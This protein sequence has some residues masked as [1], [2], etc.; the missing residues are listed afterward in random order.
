MCKKKSRDDFF[1]IHLE[2]LGWE[3]L[4]LENIPVLVDTHIYLLIHIIASE[5]IFSVK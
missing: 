2:V 4:S 1:L 3:T 5:K